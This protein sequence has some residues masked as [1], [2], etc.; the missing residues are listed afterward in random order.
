MYDV[1]SRQ[2][3]T[4]LLETKNR[5]Q[6]WAG[7]EALDSK[8]KQFL[9]TLQNSNTLL[10][11]IYVLERLLVNINHTCFCVEAPKLVMAHVFTSKPLTLILT[12]SSVT[13]LT[14]RLLLTG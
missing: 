12:T 7:L 9:F 13:S 4:K 6:L 1:F 5:F 2:P 3:P 14:T 10:L 11:L 8:R